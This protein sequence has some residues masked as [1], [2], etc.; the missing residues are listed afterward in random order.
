MLGQTGHMFGVFG[1][2][3]RTW[4]F[5]WKTFPYMGLSQ[6]CQPILS[7]IRCFPASFIRTGASS[8][9]V[10]I[11]KLIVESPCL[12]S[13]KKTITPQ[14]IVQNPSKIKKVYLSYHQ[15]PMIFPFQ[16][17]PNNSDLPPGTPA[18]P[19]Y[20]AASWPPLRSP[21]GCWRWAAHPRRGGRATSVTWSI[22]SI[23]SI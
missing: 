3:T 17:W 12:S 4:T 23:K 9:W 13:P 10:K 6:D 21:P 7:R 22:N 19:A 15:F 1:L 18:A 20:R 8:W 11:D 14:V 5:G 16:K 2:K